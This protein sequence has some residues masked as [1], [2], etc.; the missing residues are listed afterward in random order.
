MAYPQY[1]KTYDKYLS[2]IWPEYSERQF[3]K[4]MGWWWFV[5]YGF[6]HQVVIRPYRPDFVS[7]RYRLI[8]EVEG[9]G[10]Y[11]SG[12]IV[13]DQKYREYQDARHRRLYD[14]GWQIKYVWFE[15]IRDKPTETR[16]IVK[17]WVRRQASPWRRVLRALQRR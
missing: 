4:L 14:M 15:D 7:H 1:R 10:K 13:K 3:I 8:I 6:R 12:D 16:A 11:R 17:R 5:L 9:K 2:R